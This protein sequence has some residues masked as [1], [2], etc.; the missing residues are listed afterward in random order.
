M[1]MT[2][3]R[4]FEVQVKKKSRTGY[5]SAELNPSPDE[6]MLRFVEVGETFLVRIVTRSSKCYWLTDRRMLEQSN[7]GVAVIFRYEALRQ[8]HWMFKDYHRRSLNS[9]NPVEEIAKL[10]A[11][12]WDRIEVE[13][14]NGVVVLEELGPAYA[15][16]LSFLQE[17]IATGPAT[18][19]R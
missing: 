9:S 2:F 8:V 13:L 10:K 11:D 7:E 15:F 3:Q 4:W 18:R 19:T 16:V 5:D 12:H 6:Q 14:N 17:L 1:A